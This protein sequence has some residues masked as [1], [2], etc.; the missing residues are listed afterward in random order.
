MEHSNMELEEHEEENQ[1]RFR[2]EMGICDIEHDSS[3]STS[4]RQRKTK[5]T[6]G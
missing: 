1:N 6:H 5:K 3:G 2:A 4:E